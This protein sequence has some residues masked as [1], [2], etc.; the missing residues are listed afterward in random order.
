MKNR[1]KDIHQ[2][3]KDIQVKYSTHINFKYV[4]SELNPADM[5]TR[6]LAFE[7]FQQKLDFW[8]TG[9]E[10]INKTPVIWPSSELNCLSPKQKSLVC[11]TVVNCT[12]EGTTVAPIVPFDR[13]SS[14][15]KLLNVT[16]LVLKALNMFRKNKSSEPIETKREAK[17]HLLTIMQQQCFPNELAYLHNPK[18]MVPKLVRDLNLFIDKE[19]LIRSRGRIGKSSTHEYEVINP[20]L[21]AKDHYLT[22]LIINDCHLRCKHLG[23]WHSNNFKQSEII[24]ILD[25][26]GK[27]SRQKSYFSVSHMSEIQQFIL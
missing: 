27:T 18:G 20:V 16:S 23:I 5:V 3:I 7:K 9:P 2:L 21:I 26:K 22:S 14:L 4:P 12:V 13:Y 10:W 24:W 8:I 1:L 11:S 17:I 19:G 6:G 25:S 15:N